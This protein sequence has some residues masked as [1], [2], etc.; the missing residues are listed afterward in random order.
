VAFVVLIVNGNE[1]AGSKGTK[2][3]CKN[4]NGLACKRALYRQE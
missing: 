2:K 1:K 4:I 3:V